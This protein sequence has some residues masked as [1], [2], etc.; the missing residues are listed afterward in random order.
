MR[1]YEYGLL[2]PTEGEE[3]IDRQLRLAQSYYNAQIEAER[4]MRWDSLPQEL[5]DKIGAEQAGKGLRW[6][7]LSDQLK[8]EIRVETTKIKHRS[9]DKPFQER[10]KKVR[11]EHAADGLYSGTYNLTDQAVDS[12]RKTAQP[13]KRRNPEKAPLWW[14][15]PRFRSL[16]LGRGQG[17]FGVQIYGGGIGLEQLYGG[18]DKRVTVV[19]PPPEAYDDS[20]PRG[21]RRRL[22]RTELWI[23]AASENR[24]PVWARFPMIMHRP[25]PEGSI[26]KL[27]KIQRIPWEQ[28]KRWK[29]KALFVVDEPATLPRNGHRTVA[30]N[31]GWRKMGPGELRLATWVGSDGREGE[32][33]VGEEFTGRMAKARDIRGI[34]DKLR[35]EMKEKIACLGDIG[36]DCSRWKSFYRFHDLAND[37]SLG[38]EVLSILRAWKKRDQHLWWYERGCRSGALRYRREQYRLLAKKLAWEYD[39]LVIEDYDLRDIV[40]DPDRQQLPSRQRVEGAPSEAR[41]VLRSTGGREGC[42]VIDGESKGA[43]QVCHICGYDE[44]WNAAPRVWHTCPGCGAAWDQDVNNC[45]NMLASA[46]SSTSGPGPLD[47]EQ[48]RHVGRFHRAKKAKEEEA[49]GAESEGCSK[50]TGISL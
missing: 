43:T 50:S 1:V 44:S 47:P 13:W 35:D 33:R 40:E 23:R 28:G 6:G 25:I 10:R 19:Q 42:T 18:R 37:E 45:R 12:A 48:K 11:A 2:D 41:S 24:K 26:I 21:E 32:L 20:T 39:V 27:V 7:D 5:R 3:T 29:W 9:P 4:Q 31:L 16:K 38:E 8:E 49:A 36:I 15:M 34:R 14:A 30:V 22:Q 17:E 46:P